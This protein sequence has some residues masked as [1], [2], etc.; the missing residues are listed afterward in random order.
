M[1]KLKSL[2]VSGSV[3]LL[4]A[5]CG[6]DTPNDDNLDEDMTDNTEEVAEDVENDTEDD[7][8]DPMDKTFTLDELS[9]Y[10]GE[11]GNPAYVAVNGI[12]YD[13]TGVESWA[14]GEHAETLTAGNDYTEEIMEAEHGDAVLDGLKEVGKLVEE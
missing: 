13:V 11:N 2:L 12:V 3:L 4:L 9:E 14:G 7:A 10:D 6:T 5:A 8:A 1:N